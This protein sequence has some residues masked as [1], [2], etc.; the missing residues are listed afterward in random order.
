[1][2]RLASPLGMYF[3]RFHVLDVDPPGHPTLGLRRTFLTYTPAPL[4]SYTPLTV[5]PRPR[6]SPTSLPQACAKEVMRLY[7]AIPVFPREAMADD[8]LPTGHAVSA[9]AGR[10]G[11]SRR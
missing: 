10:A 9:G 2:H 8:V 11:G 6:S 4:F 5:L 1:M 7:P 3:M